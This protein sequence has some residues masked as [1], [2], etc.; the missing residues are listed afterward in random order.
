MDVATAT[1]VLFFFRLRFLAAAAINIIQHWLW[2]SRRKFFTKSEKSFLEDA[3]K[4]VIIEVS[5]CIFVLS[6]FLCW[7]KGGVHHKHLVTWKINP[8]DLTGSKSLRFSN[9]FR[10]VSSHYGKPRRWMDFFPQHIL[11]YAKI[12]L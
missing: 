4:N 2:R 11:G 12:S 7:W 1:V 5:R 3:S 10:V 8:K 9:F 6:L